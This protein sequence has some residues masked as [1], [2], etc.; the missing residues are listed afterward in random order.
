[1]KKL[2]LSVITILIVGAIA[3]TSCV[4]K[5][6]DNPPETYSDDP[7]LKVNATI[8]QLKNLYTGTPTLI[9]SD[10][11]VQ[12]I[13]VADDRSGNFYKQIVIQDS[14]S[15][16]PVL[17]NKSGLYSEYPIG[18]KVYIKCKGLYLGEYGKFVQ[19]GSV[20]DNT[21]ALSAIPTALIGNYVVKASYPH[22]V[23]PL[24]V[25]M[26]QIKTIG[27]SNIKWLGTLI[28][29]DSVE[30]QQAYIN[31]PWAQDPNVSSGTDAYIEDCDGNAAKQV[32]VRTS[33]YC[34]F[35][36]GLTPAGKGSITGIFTRY[37]N[38]AQLVIRD[39][40]DVNMKGPRCGGVVI[41]PAVA[42]KLDSI[43]KLF[44][45]N[46]ILLGNYKIHGVVTTSVIDSNIT[47]GNLI[48]QDESGKAVTVYFGS[49]FHGFVLGDSLVIDVTGDSL[50]NYRGSMEI[51][52]MGTTNAT[53]V[54]SGKSV[55]P[56][57]L[58]LAALNADLANTSLKDRQY[59]GALVKILLATITSTTTATY[60][61][62]NT[63]DWSKTLTDATDNIILFTRKNA[64]FANTN[65]LTGP[66]TVIGNANVYYTTNQILMRQLND[67]Y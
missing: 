32:D 15:G 1:M 53:K 37:N 4:K 28:K 55:T 49:N 8:L 27:T 51:K 65:F 26:A 56:V 44:N 52:I 21:N 40:N 18:R 43:R 2:L 12:G 35:R 22:E 62:P 45:G 54:A 36:N 46:N 33:G 57:T 47:K 30:F 13:V 42:V 39:T 6:F 29:L 14:T 20:P 16:I 67:V 3:F 60:S 11:T 10:W 7:G 17:L 19:L 58:T 41:L 23:V 5:N 61:G 59:E 38:Y 9:D 48:L 66:K 25:T 50:L 24:T 64:L 34:N 63:A 31:T